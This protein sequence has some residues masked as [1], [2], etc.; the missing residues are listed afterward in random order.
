M[1][2]L[3]VMLFTVLVFVGTAF[4]EGTS[5]NP[6]D[7][8][9]YDFR[10][11]TWGMT[12]EEVIASE[13]KQ[14]DFTDKNTIVYK[15]KLLSM[16]ALI[17]YIFASDQLVRAKYILKT[18]HSNKQSYIQDFNKIITVLTQ[19]YGSPEEDKVYITDKLYNDDEG[20]A[21]ATGRKHRFVIW[22]ST[23][24]KICAAL[25]CDNYKISPAVEYMSNKL[26][27]LEKEQNKKD[28][29]NEL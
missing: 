29:E 21:Y 6:I 4:A 5:P 15:G 20:M 3:I 26:K 17:G 8:R 19:K 1:K 16:D 9:K 24:T 12:R 25:T 23:N 7:A 11:S 10:H 18:E 13:G 14:P 22:E 28:S 2:K 27:N